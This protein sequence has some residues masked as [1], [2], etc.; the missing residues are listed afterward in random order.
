VG[1][2]L[3]HF[4]DF[5]GRLNERSTFVSIDANTPCRGIFNQMDKLVRCL[6]HYGLQDNP[7]IVTGYSL[8]KIIINN[9]IT[10]ESHHPATALNQELS[11]DNQLTHWARLM[12]AVFH[13]AIIDGK[14]RRVVSHT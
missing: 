1:N 14:P 13:F 5:E 10:Y 6:A 8:E 11:C 7:V 4:T 12:P 9:G 2:S 3:H